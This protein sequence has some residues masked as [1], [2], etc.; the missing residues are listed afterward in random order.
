M[1][2]AKILFSQQQSYVQTETQETVERCLQVIDVYTRLVPKSA[3]YSAHSAIANSPIS[4]VCQSAN[5]RSTNPKIPNMQSSLV[6]QSKNRKS[7]NLQEIISISDQDQH[8]L[9]LKIF[10]LFTVR[11]YILDYEMAL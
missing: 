8:W 2:C 10:F 11:K 1:S 9:P 5:R 6:S 4:E 3:N 7:A